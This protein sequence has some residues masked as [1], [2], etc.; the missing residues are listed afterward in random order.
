[1][2]IKPEGFKVLDQYI[3]DHANLYHADCIEGI[4]ALPSSSIDFAG[5][6][7][8]FSG[9]GR[10]LFVYSADDRDVG[11]SKGDGVFEEHMSF[12]A[13]ELHR[14]LKPGR[15]CAIHCMDIGLTMTH[16]GVIGF[17]DFPGQL[18]R[19]YEAAGFIYCGRI[20]IWKDPVIAEQRSHA[21]NLG[22]HL[23]VED[24]TMSSVGLPD[25]ILLMRR[26][27]KNEVP[28]K[29]EATDPLAIKDDSGKP[30]HWQQVASPVWSPVGKASDVWAT[31]NGV[32][33]GDSFVDYESPR[34]GNP[35]KRGIDQSDTLNFRAAR[36]HADERHVC[37]T[38]V[39]VVRRLLELYTNPGEVVIS[40]FLG[41]GTDVA[42]A[43]EMGRRGVGFE[44]KASY[45]RQSVEHVKRVE[46]GAKGQQL[47]I[48]DAPVRGICADCGTA[49]AIGKCSMC[50]GTVT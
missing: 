13:P 19:T 21:R 37:P 20:T 12:L 45:F 38:Q 31:S 18:V 49:G 36:E 5:F 46:P 1:M 39:G 22:H 35:D 43:V 33:E 24:S 48:T 17:F 34:A 6:S 50:G 9:R 7:P 11:N 15:M 23:M 28:V 8:P 3:S 27:G 40:P 2:L 29:H 16:H 25:Y 14:V 30:R 4:R 26:A 42:V 41:I 44:L 10:D 32:Y 47:D